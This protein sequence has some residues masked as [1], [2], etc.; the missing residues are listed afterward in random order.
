[1]LPARPPNGRCDS[2]RFVE[3][4]MLT[5]PAL[6]RSA[7]ARPRSRFPVNTAAVSP[8]GEA[9][10]SSRASAADRTSTTG[11]TGPN[12]SSRSIAMPGVTP[13]STVGSAYSWVG[14]PAARR[15]PQQ[16]RAPPAT[17]PAMCRSN[18]AA[19]ASLFSGPIVV[20]GSNGSPSRTLDLVAATTRSVNSA[21]TA[22]CTRNRSPAVQLWPAHRYA[23]S[24]AAAV[25]SS[26]SASSSI[27]IGPLPPSSSSCALPAARAATWLPVSTE[28]TKPTP[29]TPGC[30][31]RASPTT[32]PGPGTKL[33]TPAGI[34]VW[35]ITSAR[36]AQH[37]VVDGAGT[38]TTVLPAA[39][40]GANTSAP[41]VYGQFHG[42]TTPITPSGTRSVRIRRS[43]ETEAGSAPARR[44]ASSAAILKY[45]ASSSTSSNASASGL[46]WSRVRVRAS[47]SRRAPMP[48]MTLPNQPARSN[49]D[50][51]AHAGQAAEAALTASSTSTG[52]AT[53]TVANVS[54][55]DGLTAAA[56]PAPP[57]RQAPSMYSRYS[58]M[59]GLPLSSSRYASAHSRPSLS[60]DS[61]CIRNA[62]PDTDSAAMQAPVPPKTGEAAATSPSSSSATAVA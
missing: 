39:I 19:V 61:G 4:L 30:P 42:L 29:A 17:A 50:T 52:L 47:S 13:S 16:I 62:G 26:R 27:T 22:A 54:P 34:P 60:S 44:L 38:Q 49:A 3:A 20:R 7:N 32:G 37:A 21:R 2:H 57:K 25:A 11:T 8:N 41:I 5:Q 51:P 48:A 28:P 46:P 55:D 33:K 58:C 12:V 14:K 15:P 40:A 1:M 23:A 59:P 53:A 24:R 6:A 36:T 35:A 56:D 18:L 31:T 45:S 43:A 10:V 9:L